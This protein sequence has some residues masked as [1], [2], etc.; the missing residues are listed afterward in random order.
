MK[1][2]SNKPAVIKG[3]ATQVSFDFQITTD[4]VELWASPTSRTRQEKQIYDEQ[5]NPFYRTVQVIMAPVGNYTWVRQ[6]NHH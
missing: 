3:I 6:E 2:I 4:P 5:F 1:N